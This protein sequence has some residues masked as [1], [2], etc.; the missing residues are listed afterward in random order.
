MRLDLPGEWLGFGGKLN[1]GGLTQLTQVAQLEA[2]L[3]VIGGGSAGAMAAIR[4]KELNPRVRVVVFEKGHVKYSGSIVRGMD[5]LNIV[6]IPG[7]ASPRDYVRMIEQQCEGVVDE[8]SNFVL[9]KRS[10]P[11]MQKLASWGVHFPQD[12][13]GN[14]ETLE[15]NPIARFVVTMKQPELKTML[16][17]RL[18]DA[19]CIVLNR[20]MGIQLLTDEGR[21]CGAVGLNTRTGEVVVC[22]ARAVILAAGGA[23][24]FG[25]PNSGYL[26]GTFDCPANTGDAYALAFS[27]G[28]ELT[29]LEYTTCTYVVK[30]LNAPILYIT[31]TRGARLVDVLGELVGN[32][33]CPSLERM[34][35]EHRRDRGPL[36]ISMRHL[37]RD[38]IEA[39]EDILFS[40]ERPVLKRFLE[41]RGIDFRTGEVD[42]AP[43]EFFLCGGHG[44]TGVAVDERGAASVPGLYAA[45]DACNVGRGYLTGALVFGEI[46]AESA[47]ED[48]PMLSATAGD[49]ERNEAAILAVLRAWEESRG[50]LGLAEFEYKVRRTINDFVLP[51][52]SEY[53]LLRGVE[54][55]EVLRRE[56]LDQVRVRGIFDTVKALEVMNIITCALLS[57]RASLER[58]E[59]R[60]GFWHFRVDFPATSNQYRAHVVVRR[61]DYPE[62][63]VTYLRPARTLK[64]NCLGEG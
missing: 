18:A 48:L 6:T 62:D 14:Y 53:K 16:A 29:G 51:P 19:G 33:G 8:I 15:T 43:T 7:V 30:D 63:V 50:C 17:S 39:I 28:A 12:E 35:E 25:L 3:L 4:A 64:E 37:P 40:T 9:A 36:R 52:K 22:R 41:R 31:L 5:A 11:L 10:W 26:Y 61:G 60:W 23:A 20:T 54:A 21:V 46:A 45:G 24:R 13:E 47:L 1:E 49:H 55:L 57:A 2:D 27:A 56:L 42:L 38:Q 32:N 44:I 59:S 58:K 34:M